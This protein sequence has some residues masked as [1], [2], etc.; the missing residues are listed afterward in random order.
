[1]FDTFRLY[2]RW[3]RNKNLLTRVEEAFDGLA[4]TRK[5]IL[6][7]WANEI[8][9][10]VENTAFLLENS[11]TY[12]DILKEQTKLSEDILE[13]VLIDSHKM[14]RY[15]SAEYVKSKK[16]EYDSTK[17]CEALDFTIVGKTQLLF[18][19]YIDKDTLN[20]KPKSSKFHDKVTLLFCK[21]VKIK[22]EDMV[23]AARVPNDVMGDLIQ[24]EAGHIFKE[25]GDNYIFMVEAYFDKNIKTGTALSRSRFEDDTFSFG[26]NLKSGVHTDYGTISVKD[27]T[28]F[29]IVFTDPATK[30]L[31]P[32]VARTAKNGSNIFCKYPGYP[33]YR[34]I[35]VI[36]KGITFGMPHS[37]DKWGMMCEGDLAEVY[38]MKQFRVFIA[39]KV[40]LF[41]LIV[42]PSA[43]FVAKLLPVSD[44]IKV[45]IASGA[46]VL[47]T[48]IF[49]KQIISDFFDK[50]GYLR[51]F[52]RELVEGDRDITNRTNLNIFK[53]DENLKTAIW[54]NSVVDIFD[55]VISKTK[56]SIFGLLNL[57]QSLN[58]NITKADVKL[59]EVEQSVKQ[60]VKLISEQNEFVN[61]SVQ[62]ATDV[63]HE[64]N[65]TQRTIVSD[66]EE[67]KNSIGDIKIIV[68]DTTGNITMLENNVRNITTMI[69][70]IKDITD[71]TNLLSLNAAVEASRAGEAGRGFAVVAEEVRKLAEMTA[72]ATVQIE[73][74]VNNINQNVADT[75]QSMDRVNSTVDKS[76]EISSESV[77]NINKVLENQ[78]NMVDNVKSDIYAIA[79][80]SKTNMEYANTVLDE[81]KEMD[82]L[83]NEVKTVSHSVTHHLSTL[84][85]TVSSFKT[86]Q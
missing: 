54:I 37:L 69:D 5:R 24:R 53:K 26:E 33:D 2:L 71:K 48:Y 49:I 61:V 23:L 67:V 42:V 13:Y 9:R 57:N 50:N 58:T 12:A 18:G 39:L 29:E 22:D 34:G 75:L 43:Y 38:D 1:M 72:K 7:E 28:E 52:L 55:S 17:L 51:E 6:I 74:M 27:H 63:T 84:S 46:V 86:S 25:S 81:L 83:N 35:P 11:A 47:A 32:G 10:E 76:I 31:H 36:G 66:I 15:S 60:T 80:R 45:A 85:K 78:V 82:S 65:S 44:Y 20:F 16:Y 77:G 19:P 21:Y 79:K 40:F 68:D 64:I 30:E 14:L 73:S 4:N 62:K 8:W 70:T 59:K 41:A 56:K 3:F